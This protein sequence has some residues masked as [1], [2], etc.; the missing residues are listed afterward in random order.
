MLDDLD[1]Y[2][3]E[4]DFSCEKIQEE[5]KTERRG[6]WFN[7]SYTSSNPTFD[8]A[9][10]YLMQQ[11]HFSS[12]KKN[13][14][15]CLKCILVNISRLANSSETSLIYRRG[16]EFYTKIR[17]NKYANPLCITKTLIPIV[18]ALIDNG[19]LDGET[20]F[21]SQ[22]WKSSCSTITPTEKM[23]CLLDEY[24]LFSAEVE[25]SALTPLVVVRNEN[26]DP[27]Q[28]KSGETARLERRVAKI[29]ALLKETD[30]RIK[31]YKVPSSF[32]VCLDDISLYR[33]FNNGG[34]KE[35]GRFYG[36]FWQ[37]I[38]SVDRAKILINGEQTEELD[39]SGQHIGMLY[40]LLGHEIPDSLRIDPYKIKSNIPRKLLKVAILCALN[41]NSSVIARKAAWSKLLEKKKAFET[42]QELDDKKEFRALIKTNAQFQELMDAFLETHPLLKN[43]MFK[44]VGPKLQ[45]LD[46]EIADYILYTMAQKGIPVLPVHDSFIVQK[47]YK[48]E[49]LDAMK[50]A[51]LN[52]QNPLL[53][54]S[55]TSIKDA[56]KNVYQFKN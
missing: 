49:L 52:S 5:K 18:D 36:G 44:G 11:H 17:S 26:K 54:K 31:D 23:E 6:L 27:I 24:E 25:K 1:L 9:V 21:F 19:Y 7:L 37:I 10:E 34:L 8:A 53:R 56:R 39:F 22:N 47:R 43:G 48:N 4:R 2:N 15:K 45:R 12:H 3:Y 35:G 51:Y 30:I 33:V 46:S 41:C 50:S 42:Q 16:H 28:Y 38:S 14:K 20:G 40:A 13:V 29:N 32:P 55:Y